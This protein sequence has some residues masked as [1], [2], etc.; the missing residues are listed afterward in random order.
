[1]IT[2]LL[3]GVSAD[4]F[5]GAHPPPRKCTVQEGKFCNKLRNKMNLDVDSKICQIAFAFAAKGPPQNPL[6]KLTEEPVAGISEVTRRRGRRHH[7]GMI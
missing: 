2:R 6:G 7:K 5:S 1:M 3:T 4:E